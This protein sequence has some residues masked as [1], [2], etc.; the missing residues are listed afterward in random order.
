MAKWGEG[1]G[2]TSEVELPSFPGLAGVRSRK[3][4]LH[5]LEHN[6]LRGILRMRGT[7]KETC[8][9][10]VGT[11]GDSRAAPMQV[12]QTHW[13]VRH[14]SSF[15][16]NAGLGKD[17]GRREYHQ[18]SIILTLTV[19]RIWGKDGENDVVAIELAMSS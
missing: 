6:V 2:I 3:S 8:S 16:G 11:K 5:Q 17:R 19:Y 10:S 13:P 15:T 9:E 14:G 12:P 1:K 4:E 18:V 7:R